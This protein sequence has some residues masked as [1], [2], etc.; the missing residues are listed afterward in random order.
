MLTTSI[1]QYDKSSQSTPL[2]DSQAAELRLWTAYPFG[3]RYSQ[4]VLLRVEAADLAHLADEVDVF[5]VL[6]LLTLAPLVFSIE[7]IEAAGQDE[8]AAAVRGPA[9][10]AEDEL[11]PRAKLKD[12]YRSGGI[13][14][15]SLCY[16][17]Q[18]SGQKPSSD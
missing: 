14:C 1:T 16:F 12:R 15:L 18:D 5:L 3:G 7:V 11:L 6:R 2:T 8:V 4:A 17:H 9:V 13:K 10:R